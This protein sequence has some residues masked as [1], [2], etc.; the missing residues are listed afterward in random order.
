MPG[1]HRHSGY[2]RDPHEW[3]VEPRWCVEQ[4]LDQ[5]ELDGEP[6]EGAVIDPCCGGGT[7]P[8]ACLARGIPARGSDIVD[9]GFGTVCNL[10]DITEP[11][12]NVMSNVPY[13]ISV[14]CLR[15][16]LT[17]VRRRILLLL[18]LTFWG[19]RERNALFRVSPP[20]LFYP[21]SDRPSMPPGRMTGRRDPLGAL[22]QPNNSGG[23]A[24][25][26]W[27]RFDIGYRGP[28]EVRLLDLRPL[29]RRQL[30]LP[31]VLKPSPSAPAQASLWE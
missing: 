12:D 18:P 17:F 13:K 28:M 27:W 19:S 25:Y 9:R 2:P 4:M 16:M 6:F 31:A 30:S 20:R 24:E 1:L 23:T 8:S 3:Y 10:F 7:I 22:I 21:C 5:L 11:V 29:D 15:H 14:P 26:G